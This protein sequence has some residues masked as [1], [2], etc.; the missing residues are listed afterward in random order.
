MAG[1]STLRNVSGIATQYVHMVPHD[2]P[3]LASTRQEDSHPPLNEGRAH[4]CLAASACSIRR[5]A[6]VD[7]SQLA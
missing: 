6:S 4:T 1:R 7:T 5:A 3:E 2:V